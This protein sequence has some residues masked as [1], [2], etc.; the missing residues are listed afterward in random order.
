MPRRP[1][2]PAQRQRTNTPAPPLPHV[3]LRV[4]PAAVTATWQHPGTQRAWDA[5]WRSPLAVYVIEPDLPQL[6]RL[7]ELYDERATLRARQAKAGLTV[8]GSQGQRVLNPIH[9]LVTELS[10]QIAELEDRY[11]ISP[12]A[13]RKLNLDLAA[14][15]EERDDADR[16]PR[17]VAIT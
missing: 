3:Q 14:V 4:D 2:D 11:G 7:H 16:A 13:R 9:K 10:S 5:F 12:D 6:F 1:K 17:L 15:P 8:K